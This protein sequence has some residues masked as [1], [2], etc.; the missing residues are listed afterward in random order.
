MLPAVP[1]I[2]VAQLAEVLGTE[3]AP[4]LLDVREAAELAADSLPGIVHIPLAELPFRHTELPSGQ[5]IAVICRSGVRSAHATA[6]LIS[7]GYQA[8]NVE[9]GMLAYRNAQ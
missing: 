2:T 5:S 8:A 7:E 6:F 9:G 3:N 1:T 4:L